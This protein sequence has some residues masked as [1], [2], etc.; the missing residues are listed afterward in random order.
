MSTRT[1]VSADFIP[2]V[3][4]NCP[5]SAI[6]RWVK[7]D[8]SQT[9]RVRTI[10]TTYYA[11]GTSKFPDL[12]V[13]SNLLHLKITVNEYERIFYNLNR[14]W[15]KMRFTRDSSAYVCDEFTGDQK[16]YIAKHDNFEYFSVIELLQ[17]ATNFPK[18][19]T[20][21]L[22]S[23]RN[24][25]PF[26]LSLCDIDGMQCLER[27]TCPR[28]A[29]W[30]DSDCEEPRKINVPNLTV[31]NLSG[32]EIAH[33]TSANDRDKFCSIYYAA[34]LFPAL[35][36]LAANSFNVFVTRSSGNDNAETKLK[37]LQCNKIGIS[38]H[39]Y[40]ELQKLETLDILGHSNNQ[41]FVVSEELL[42]Q[43]DTLYIRNGSADKDGSF[44]N[45]GFIFDSPHS[46]L[47]KLYLDN[48]D[49]RMK[50]VPNDCLC[51]SSA[52]LMFP[53]LRVLCLM[54]QAFGY[55]SQS[56]F[57]FNKVFNSLFT[58]QIKR[59]DE[60]Q[61]ANY[62]VIYS[63]D[64][65]SRRVLNILM[66]AA[67]YDVNIRILDNYRIRP[68]ENLQTLL[69]KTKL[70]HDE[71]REQGMQVHNTM[72]LIANRAADRHDDDTSPDYDDCPILNMDWPDEILYRIL[73]YVVR[74]QS[75]EFKSQHDELRDQYLKHE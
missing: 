44:S 70:L 11:T 41:A 18:L 56:S 52:D 59:L 32:A 45:R 63:K 69:S 37:Y 73:E 36:R 17:L 46:K 31:L 60:I 28:L 50:N 47:R 29:D 49:L 27:L 68:V 57:D 20:L 2:D 16:S 5:M 10:K 3:T 34:E 67:K 23:T 51:D 24:S 1:G 43:L 9:R 66:T 7:K 33:G 65:P 75:I 58:L 8:P 61:V 38:R 48:C 62:W 12:S 6:E 13:F 22:L 72:L 19:K 39:G 4:L 15:D 26:K 54:S 14:R 35:E 25:D 40:A 74:A 42:P 71:F 55:I 53:S 21:V 30:W 64:S